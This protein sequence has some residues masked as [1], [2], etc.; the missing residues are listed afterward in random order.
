MQF[1]RTRGFS[2]KAEFIATRALQTA[3]DVPVSKSLVYDGDVE[4]LPFECLLIPRE[5]GEPG[6]GFYKG[7]SRE[8]RLQLGFPAGPDPGARTQS[9]MSG[10]ASVGEYKGTGFVGGDGPGRVIR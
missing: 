3:A 10:S 2:L 5:P 7:A 6:V 4:P 1:R 9:A 8:Q